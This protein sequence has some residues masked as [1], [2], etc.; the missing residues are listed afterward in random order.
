VCEASPFKCPNCGGPMANLGRDLRLPGKTKNEQWKAIKYL[1][2][3]NYNIY[4]CGC[5][6]IGF[7]PHKLS[8]AVELVEA[9]RE[10][11]MGEQLLKRTL[12]K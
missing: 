1:Y 4:S 7:V 3:N 6:G 9:C 8:E 11:T 10:K 5:Q 12:I 2:E